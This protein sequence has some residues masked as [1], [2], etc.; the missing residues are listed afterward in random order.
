M[1]QLGQISP[2][3]IIFFGIS[4]SL[5]LLFYFII[6]TY[7]IPAIENRKFR[8]FVAKWTF[9]SELLLWVGFIL[10][11]LDRFIQSSPA[12]IILI[13]TLSLILGWYF[14]RD[15]I[16][17]VVFRIE[18]KAKIGD[19]IRF[20][21]LEGKIL[22]LGNRNLVIQNKEKLKIVIPNHSIAQK[23]YHIIDQRDQNNELQITIDPK[24]VEAFGGMKAFRKLLYSNPWVHPGENAIITKREGGDIHVIVKTIH[25]GDQQ[26]LEKYIFSE[27]DKVDKPS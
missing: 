4:L 8:S 14:W 25:Q 27:L 15:L 12:L 3:L 6:N 9:R 2:M 16:S 19:T 18:Q 23:G 11:F 20:G 13:I 10:F 5:L 7:V 1:N 17:G 24:Q 22:S 21:E 26:N